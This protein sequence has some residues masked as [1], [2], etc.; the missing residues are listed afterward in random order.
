MAEETKTN[1]VTLEELCREQPLD[2]RRIG[3]ATDRQGHHHRRRVQSTTECG[4]GELS[5]RAETPSL[6][7]TVPCFYF[8][9]QL[10]TRRNEYSLFGS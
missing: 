10:A 4:A 8:H 5:I 7:I 3:E 1:K 6:K 2:D 9:C